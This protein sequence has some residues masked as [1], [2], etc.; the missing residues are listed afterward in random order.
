MLE[1]DAVSVLY[2]HVATH[3][4]STI[5]AHAWL[6]LFGVPDGMR[7]V[8]MIPPASSHRIGLV[9]PDRVPEPMLARALLDVAGSVDMRAALDRLLRRLVRSRS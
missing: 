7:I 6:H 8:P 4:W 9:L 2:A 3:R 5:I 1:A